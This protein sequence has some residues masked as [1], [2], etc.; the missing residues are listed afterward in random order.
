MLKAHEGAKMNKD[1]DEVLKNQND[2]Q[3]GIINSW[4]MSYLDQITNKNIAITSLKTEKKKLTAKVNS[5]AK[6]IIEL[7]KKFE[8]IDKK[9]TKETKQRKYFEGLYKEEREKNLD[10]RNEAFS[11]RTFRSQQFRNLQKK[12]K[13]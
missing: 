9:W 10:L 3:K 13:I 8:E 5:Q 6:K 11:V 7:E 2:I 4:I 12:R 1:F